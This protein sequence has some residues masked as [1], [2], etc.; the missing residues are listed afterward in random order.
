MISRSKEASSEALSQ[1]SAAPSSSCSAAPRERIYSLADLP[2]E[3]VTTIKIF[4]P[5]RDIRSLAGADRRFLACC[6]DD[7]FWIKALNNE[8]KQKAETVEEGKAYPPGAWQIFL[9][10]PELRAL[11][12]WIVPPP[13]VVPAE[14]V[15]ANDAPLAE[16]QL[17]TVVQPGGLSPLRT[18]KHLYILEC[19]KTQRVVEA[20]VLSRLNELRQAAGLT[21]YLSAAQRAIRAI[22]LAQPDFSHP[23]L[24]T[25][26]VTQAIEIRD[27]LTCVPQKEDLLALQIPVVWKILV[28]GPTK[29]TKDMSQLESQA[30]G[31][32]ITHK[33]AALEWAQGRAA[34][35]LQQDPGAYVLAAH[36]AYGV[37]LDWLTKALQI[38]L[39][40]IPFNELP[41]AQTGF[42]ART[43]LLFSHR[44]L[45]LLRLPVFWQLLEDPEAFVMERY[46]G[47][48][49]PPGWKDA[50][51]SRTQAL[52]ALLSA[53]IHVEDGQGTYLNKISVLGS[54]VRDGSLIPKLRR[55]YEHLEDRTQTYYAWEQAGLPIPQWEIVLTTRD[56]GQGPVPH[57]PPHPTRGVGRPDTYLENTTAYAAYRNGDL[58]LSQLTALDYDHL[59]LIA[60]P[61]G[62]AW[63][64]C[65]V[66][67]NW[68]ELSSQFRG[69]TT[70]Q[71]VGSS[72]E[73]S[74]HDSLEQMN[75]TIEVFQHRKLAALVEAKNL[76][77][78]Q[79]LR[80]CQPM[81]REGWPIAY[82]EALCDIVTPELADT[83][84]DSWPPYLDRTVLGS[85]ELAQLYSKNLISLEQWV[86][87]ARG[88]S[89]PAIQYFLKPSVQHALE[90]GSI[91]AEDVFE[92]PIELD[93]GVLDDWTNDELLK[94]WKLTPSQIL[95]L[96]S[97][98]RD[99]TKQH[100]VS[101]CVKRALHDL[102]LAEWSRFDQ[103]GQPLWL[104]QHK[105]PILIAL[106]SIVMR[107]LMDWGM[108]PIDEVY[109]L[110]RQPGRCTFQLLACP[111]VLAAIDHALG[112]AKGSDW[113]VT[114][115]APQIDAI[116]Q[117]VTSVLAW[118]PDE[119]T[120]PPAEVTDDET[121]ATLVR[122]GLLPFGSTPHLSR[123]NAA[124]LKMPLAGFAMRTLGLTW[125]ATLD[126]LR[127]A[128]TYLCDRSGFEAPLQAGLCTLREVGTSGPNLANLAGLFPRWANTWQGLKAQG[129]TWQ[130][131]ISTS[132]RFMECARSLEQGMGDFVRA[133]A[134]TWLTAY[135]QVECA[136]P[137]PVELPEGLL[138]Q[139][140]FRVA[141][142]QASDVNSRRGH[143]SRSEPVRAVRVSPDDLICLLSA[144]P[145]NRPFVLPDRL[146]GGLVETLLTARANP[147]RR[148]ADELGYNKR[149]QHLLKILGR[150]PWHQVVRCAPTED[151]RKIS[152]EDCAAIGW[153]R[154]QPVGE[155]ELSPYTVRDLK[156]LS[157]KATAS[158]HFRNILWKIPVQELARLKLLDGCDLSKEQV[159]NLSLA[160][161]F[162]LLPNASLR[163]CSLVNKIAL[164]T[165]LIP[166][167]IVGVPISLAMYVVLGLPISVMGRWGEGSERIWKECVH[168][169][170][171]LFP[172]QALPCL[173]PTWWRNRG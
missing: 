13:V 147:P 83:V 25:L 131:F 99:D 55:R 130:T 89:Q 62:R 154:Q 123:D 2:D 86:T 37:L 117:I 170:N 31:M 116:R 53:S 146:V 119:G 113:V 129:V 58:S 34:P 29:Q 100:L 17:P 169:W 92:W 110:G 32:A 98:N 73:P 172:L 120:L 105:S 91:Q 126:Q 22:R 16:A 157:Q 156:F 125:D 70:Q 7:R 166:V 10:H 43:R 108:L 1:R 20:H 4:L 171:L 139:L 151:L 103:T 5:L 127:H 30:A 71:N 67:I 54:L 65:G 78:S 74:G 136:Q 45:A 85:K 106:N 134:G 164:W 101:L 142:G 81:H 64:N 33:T 149:M 51:P 128:G 88:K 109:K 82:L 77:P 59:K 49:G 46:E 173:L 115:S 144:H 69:R 3:I 21:P 48:A 87:L 137:R 66:P 155:R 27:L 79:L 57:V 41:T 35:G 72:T 143:S 90:N 28:D 12:S 114:P 80:L 160:Q 104:G 153:D 102:G 38:D 148:E 6:I 138:D 39:A 40:P 94:D 50:L 96:A 158:E 107:R 47:E 9:H 97:L 60:S 111:L 118:N 44:V 159:R 124:K 26:L 145:D 61:C 75:R 63:V 14:E 168:T 140:E 8:G 165:A 11:P 15:D 150:C 84:I 68:I 167:E 95:E 161:Q 133:H 18:D 42:A 24:Q 163:K 141:E 93:F 56:A 36:V 112:V 52:D 23:A 135:C 122:E 121:M 132:T 76:H 19:A 152:N 162:T